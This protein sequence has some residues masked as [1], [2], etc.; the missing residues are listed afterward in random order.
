MTTK[1]QIETERQRERIANDSVFGIWT[2]AQKKIR[3]RITPVN[4][5]I[6]IRIVEILDMSVIDAI[7]F[8]CGLEVTPRRLKWTHFD[9][10]TN[11]RRH[12]NPNSYVFGEVHLPFASQRTIASLVIGDKS[13][14]QLNFFARNEQPE[15]CTGSITFL[16]DRTFRSRAH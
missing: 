10:V 5:S 7:V 13:Q 15:I 14:L 3:V 11:L 6:R 4:N 9:L 16:K 2:D 8:F 1:A 12:F